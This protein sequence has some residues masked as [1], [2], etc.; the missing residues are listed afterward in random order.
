[1]IQFGYTQ[2][3]RLL[4]AVD[5]RLSTPFLIVNRVVVLWKEEIHACWD[6]FYEYAPHFGLI[7]IIMS[8]QHILFCRLYKF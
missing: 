3:A 6:N 7:R 2:D 8:N 5:V 4:S 1:M